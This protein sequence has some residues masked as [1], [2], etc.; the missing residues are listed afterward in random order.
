MFSTPRT[1][2]VRPDYS[3][4]TGIPSVSEFVTCSLDGRLW[5]YRRSRRFYIVALKWDEEAQRL[6]LAGS[7]TL[8]NINIIGRGVDW[9]LTDSLVILASDDEPYILTANLW[10]GNSTTFLYSALRSGNMAETP[11][12]FT[13]SV[14]SGIDPFTHDAWGKSDSNGNSQGLGVFNRSALLLSV[15]KQYSLLP[16]VG[17]WFI[18]SN[19]LVRR[20]DN[21]LSQGYNS[22]LNLRPL[23]PL[24]FN[25]YQ[26]NVSYPSYGSGFD[27][28]I[29]IIHSNGQLWARGFMHIGR[30]YILPAVFNEEGN[31]EEFY[32]YIS[33]D[34]LCS[35]FNLKDNPN[36]DS[37][38]DWLN[39]SL[40]AAGD[41]SLYGFLCSLS[42][43]L[44]NGLCL[45]SDTPKLLAPSSGQ[46]QT[47]SENGTLFADNI[48]HSG[49]VI[50]DE[51]AVLIRDNNTPYECKG[52]GQWLAPAGS[53]DAMAGS[54]VI[55]S[56]DNG[57]IASHIQSGFHR[58]LMQEKK[59]PLTVK[60]Y[61]GKRMS[62][63]DTSNKTLLINS[64][65][66]TSN[67]AP[68]AWLNVYRDALNIQALNFF[69]HDCDFLEC[70]NPYPAFITHYEEKSMIFV[71]DYGFQTDLVSQTEFDDQGNIIFIAPPELCGHLVEVPY[72]LGWGLNSQGSPYYP[73][74]SCSVHIKGF[75]INPENG[76]CVP[77]DFTDA[78]SSNIVLIELYSSHPEW[79]I[80]NAERWMYDYYNKN[81]TADLP[82]SNPVYID[83][84]KGELGFLYIHYT[85]TKSAGSS[86]DFEREFKFRPHVL[87]PQSFC[88]WRDNCKG[89]LSLS[90]VLIPQNSTA[91][92]TARFSERNSKTI[93]LCNI[94]S[95]LN[96][97]N[98]NASGSLAGISNPSF[99][100]GNFWNSNSMNSDGTFSTQGLH[101]SAAELEK[102]IVLRSELHPE[103]FDFY[104]ESQRSRLS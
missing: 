10:D 34:Y 61:V 29:S 40:L 69:S 24:E 12:G 90:D 52:L 33:P 97:T 85:I 62:V 5:V 93:F 84:E 92:A 81:T 48:N 39:T 9:I 2:N 27:H 60:S 58:E 46:W 88:N 25:I 96:I 53:V 70:L 79:G 38:D 82:D 56:W 28:D 55:S 103:I 76:E 104:S 20:P 74:F 44:D 13:V 87:L 73:S 72:I 17:D 59:L 57:T 78:L 89:N 51:G 16:T 66:D 41:N 86:S 19:F 101:V 1:I 26:G 35:P 7:S 102:F 95:A 14:G 94:P 11:S 67:L 91:S 37:S 47:I 45:T 43:S 50:H 54:S 42:E 36:P 100:Y 75:Y 49:I 65:E 31:P 99:S 15:S 6:E 30:C 80:T 64:I 23:I 71:D 63:S 77:F 18:I 8:S 21:P 68:V 3:I 83:P 4:D 98:G 32:L 22:M